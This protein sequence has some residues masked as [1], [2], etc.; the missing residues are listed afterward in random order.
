MTARTDEILTRSL[1]AVAERCGDPA[2]LVY[3]RLFEAFPETEALFVRDH[4]GAIRGEM[5]A[6]AFQCL[7]DFDGGYAANLIR[8]ERV[9]HEGFAVPP[10]AFARFFPI[11]QAA[12]REALAEGWTDEF[13]RAWD[14][15]V[16]EIERLIA[17]VA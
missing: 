4:D 11:V 15:R 9:N 14:E 1:E 10:E 7:L 13:S 16:T 12:C 2:L 5:L 8:A 6:V 3:R 17:S